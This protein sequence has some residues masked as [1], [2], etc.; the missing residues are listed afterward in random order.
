MHAYYYSP[1][2]QIPLATAVETVARK[3]YDSTGEVCSFLFRFLLEPQ[4]LPS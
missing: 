2:L 3:Q 4:I 1:A